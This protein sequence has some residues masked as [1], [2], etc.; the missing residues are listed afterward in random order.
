MIK[1]LPE[2]ITIPENSVFL[3]ELVDPRSG[4]VRYIGKTNN[5]Q[6]RYKNHISEFHLKATTYKNSWIKSLL[7][8]NLRPLMR[9]IAITKNEY[10]NDAEIKAISQGKNL[11]NMTGGGDGQSH[12]SEEVRLKIISGRK[13]IKRPA[14][15]EETKIKIS[16]AQIGIPKPKWTNERF[17]KQCKSVIGINI[18]TGEEILFT[19]ADEAARF[20]GSNKG[21]HIARVCNGT[22]KYKTSKGYIWKW[23]NKEGQ[24]GSKI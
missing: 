5:L 6:K 1:Q 23:A 20:V 12:M 15:K 18:K 19:S 3:Y 10:I 24:N 16:Q 11:T 14:C 8:L 2:F 9:V 13:N 7:K 4:E 17:S 22:P 21:S